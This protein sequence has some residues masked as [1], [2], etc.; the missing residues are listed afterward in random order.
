MD[1]KF[2]PILSIVLILGI[3]SQSYFKL[4]YSCRLPCSH[5][6]K[7]IEN[8]ELCFYECLDLFLAQQTSSCIYLNHEERAEI[9]LSLFFTFHW[10]LEQEL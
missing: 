6:H 7:C 5:V 10:P 1:Y 2:C 9:K 3:H 4:V 8:R